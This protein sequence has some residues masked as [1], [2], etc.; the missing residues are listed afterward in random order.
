M[1]IERANYIL[2][3]YHDE[4]SLLNRYKDIPLSELDDFIG[5]DWIC[6]KAYCDDSQQ[7]NHA[8]GTLFRDFLKEFKF[9]VQGGGTIFPANFKDID[10][11]QA[12]GERKLLSDEMVRI[13]G[14]IVEKSNGKTSTTTN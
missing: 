7:S 8:K 5:I 6:M 14:L 2:E 9:Y 11:R 13:Y 3:N 4:F 12:Y 10:Y 1:K